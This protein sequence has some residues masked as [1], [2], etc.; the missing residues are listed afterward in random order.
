MR[1]QRYQTMYAKLATMRIIRS[2]HK[3]MQGK[4]V[5]TSGLTPTNGVGV[6]QSE[7]TQVKSPNVTRLSS[8]ALRNIANIRSSTSTCTF[9]AT[10]TARPDGLV[11]KVTLRVTMQGYDGPNT[12]RRTSTT[13]CNWIHWG[14]PFAHLNCDMVGFASIVQ[15]HILVNDGQPFLNITSIALPIFPTHSYLYVHNAWLTTL[16]I[17]PNTSTNWSPTITQSTTRESPYT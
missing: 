6:V 4:V 11:E 10:M 2:Q 17:L 5:S 14:I 12:T 15:F 1:A 8:T 3:A 13:F 16:S 9:L 7:R